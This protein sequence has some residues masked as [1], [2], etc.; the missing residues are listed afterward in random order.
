MTGHLVATGDDLR[1][2][3]S[4]DGS[5]DRP[6]AAERRHRTDER[7]AVLSRPESRIGGLGSSMA[8]RDG[9]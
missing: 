1:Q 4:T 2:T 3:V 8:I 7:S 9:D 5:I 6:A